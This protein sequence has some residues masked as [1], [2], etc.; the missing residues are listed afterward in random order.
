VQS[1]NF[2]APISGPVVR[3]PG[4][5][6]V[7]GWH[8][9]LSAADGT[10]RG[11]HRSVEVQKQ[12]R[13]PTRDSVLTINCHTSTPGMEQAQ[14]P[15]RRHYG[16]PSPRFRR[17]PYPEP[18]TLSARDVAAALRDQLPGL[19]TQKLH[20]LLYYCHGVTGQGGH[21]FEQ[22][23]EAVQRLA[24]GVGVTAGFAVGGVGSGGGGDGV[25]PGWGVLVG[26]GQ[27]GQRGAQVSDEV[28]DQ[29]VGADPVGQVVVDRAPGETSGAAGATRTRES[30]QMPP[31]ADSAP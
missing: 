27:F 10:E 19:P 22:A 30:P 1:D 8:A 13:A 26:V 24:V 12:P 5:A 25:V 28:A 20:K 31:C 18:I 21:V 17:E 29:H 6:P 7:D 23:T 2:R 16:S 4:P 3:P 15:G 9:G 14:A 11:E